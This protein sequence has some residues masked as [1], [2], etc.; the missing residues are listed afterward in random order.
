[1]YL[2]TLTEE[3]YDGTW[4]NPLLTMVPQRHKC[5]HECLSDLFAIGRYDNKK[6]LIERF[7]GETMR[8]RIGGDQ[9]VIING[10]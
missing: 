8:F 5:E 9:H 10:E 4:E 3:R 1:M 6:N 2:N 7:R